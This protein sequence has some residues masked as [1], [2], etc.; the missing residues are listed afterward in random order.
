MDLQYIADLSGKPTAVV[1]PIK[2]WEKIKSFYLKHINS[3]EESEV[4]YVLSGIEQA[5]NEINLVKKGKLKS[6][7]IEELLDEL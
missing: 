1:I 4:E 5:V 6:R 7:P 3:I 2:E